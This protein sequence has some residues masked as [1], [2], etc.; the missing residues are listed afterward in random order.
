MIVLLV[1]V[2]RIPWVPPECIVDPKNLSPATDKWSFGTTVWEICSGGEK[3]LANMDNSKAGQYRCPQNVNKVN[4]HFPYNTSVMCMSFQKH[5]FYENRHQLPAPK[6]TEL[7]NLI[8]CCMDY[9]PT[10]RP[11]FR[12]IIR[13]LNN[14]FCPGKYR[15]KRLIV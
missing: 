15:L 3:P 4:D 11:S 5:L 14:L 13:D 6:W 7:A 2:E 12:A 1:L 10:V 9:E 8:N